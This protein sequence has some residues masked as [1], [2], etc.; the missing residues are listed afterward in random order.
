MP[1]A[2]QRTHYQVLQVDRD[3][4]PQVV[5]G[6]YRALLKN[7]RLHPDLG[8]SQAEAQAINEAYAVLSHPERRRA[9]DASLAEAPRPADQHAAGAGPA[10][11]QYIL[12]CPA[13]RK[14]NPVQP[15]QALEAI[16]CSRCGARLLPARHAPAETDHR[17]AFRLGMLFYERRMFDR[18]RHEFQAAARL[19]PSQPTYQFWLGRSWYGSFGFEKARQCF[20]AAAQARPAQFQFQFWLGQAAYRLKDYGAALEAFQRAL[21]LRPEDSATLLRLASCQLR[22]EEPAA[23]TTLLRRALRSRPHRADLHVLLGMA[24]L[25]QQREPEARKALTRALQLK[26]GDPLAQKYLA[27]SQTGPLGAGLRRSLISLL[28]RSSSER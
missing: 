18:S 13:C 9:Y 24:L 23:A 7:A 28:G 21:A 25:I 4:S 20:Q 12:I 27:A 5:Q 8:G 19:K 10:R 22:L 14:R 26:P 1:P 6:A 16:L 11:T 3:A 2:R 17:R 15:Q